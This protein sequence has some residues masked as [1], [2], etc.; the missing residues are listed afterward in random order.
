MLHDFRLWAG[1]G[2]TPPHDAWAVWLFLGGRGAGKTRA[3]AEW[4][5]NAVA[6]GAA[7][8]IALIGQTLHAVRE[9]MIGGASGLFHAGH[10]R[11]HYEPSR[12]RLVW[13]NGA[14]AFAFS[15][16]EPDSLRGPQ[17]DAAWADEFCA[18][19]RP[20]RVMAVLRP[21]LRL[22]AR[23]RLV[24]TTTPRPIAPL[25]RLC[26]EPNVVMTHARTADNA[27]NLA[28][29]FLAEM[30]ALWGQSRL[31][32]QELLGEVLEE[33]DGALWTR[34]TLD[35]A[36]IAARPAHVD[37]VVVAVDPPA[38]SSARADACGIIVAG[39]VGDGAK[40]IA[41]VL[42]DATVQGLTPLGWAHCVR[43]AA[44][45]WGA[46]RIIAEAN[47]G[48]EMVRTTL[49]VAGV[50]IP[51]RLVRATVSKRM[52]A[53]PIAALYEGGRIRHVGALPHLET[54]MCAF[55][56]ADF[57]G[58]P[59]RLDAAVWALSDLMLARSAPSLRIL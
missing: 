19:T 59:D 30:E 29:T 6:A 49:E 7:R 51:V 50:A 34:A 2:Q 41:Y 48:G 25:K 37:D 33:Q 11:P 38:S 5:Q 4:M 24:V 46:R 36:R 22:G 47:Q 12:R 53:E 16:E 23:P 9:V 31:A 8:R 45:R 55:G 57:A 32:R 27:S 26:A 42:D 17:F 13:P 21:A 15:A 43:R 10:V 40:R 56:G 18:W 52:R 20:D 14:E 3:G 35:A 44:E 1:P 54:E 28:P 58:S 39:C